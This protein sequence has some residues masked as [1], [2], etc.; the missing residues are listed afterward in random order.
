MYRMR[1]IKKNGAPKTELARKSSPP[2]SLSSQVTES[3]STK[4]AENHSVALTAMIY[5]RELAA[6]ENFPNH[7]IWSRTGTAIRKRMRIPAQTARAACL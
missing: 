1:L 6:A 4:K 5:I 3:K 2:T 7:L